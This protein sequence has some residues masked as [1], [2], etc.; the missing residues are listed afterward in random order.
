[1]FAE[2]AVKVDVKLPSVEE[3]GVIGHHP[4]DSAE[5]PP[6]VH[7]VQHRV[8]TCLASANYEVIF[9]RVPDASQT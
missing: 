6:V 9:R 5:L 4:V 8:N 7:E 2:Y 3:P 1:M